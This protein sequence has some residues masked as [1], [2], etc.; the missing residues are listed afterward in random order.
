[1]YSKLDGMEDYTIINSY[2]DTKF[3]LKCHKFILMLNFDYILTLSRY[4][5][6][7]FT[8]LDF[9]LKHDSVKNAYLFLL[10]EFTIDDLVTVSDCLDLL[11]VLRALLF[12]DE[13][14]Q[15][16][17]ISR[18]LF[19]VNH[20]NRSD[21]MECHDSL[22]SFGD[23]LS[24][25]L[26]KS[27]DKRMT[28]L[29]NSKGVQQTLSFVT[30][31]GNSESKLFA[32]GFSTDTKWNFQIKNNKSGVHIKLVADT[33][34]NVFK[35]KDVYFFI[36]SYSNEKSEYLTFNEKSQK[37]FY[38]FCCDNTVDSFIINVKLY[39]DVNNTKKSRMCF[40][41]IFFSD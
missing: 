4:N 36:D 6:F 40:L 34:P 29:Q 17:V 28:F 13:H 1:M 30:F 32:N 10:D 8:V 14:K 26:L 16:L 19:L 2:D 5:K 22:L 11:N 23:L 37:P 3:E 21:L 27:L 33:E 24:R 25:D 38:K 15:L 39:Q 35:D 7:S 18:L 20:L 9:E 41:T 12:V 31:D